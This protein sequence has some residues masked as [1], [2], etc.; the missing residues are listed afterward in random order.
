MCERDGAAGR[1]ACS[2]LQPLLSA[3]S[4]YSFLSLFPLSMSLYPLYKEKQSPG[5][6]VYRIL[7]K[8]GGEEGRG[9]KR[10]YWGARGG[11]MIVAA[12]ERGSER[13]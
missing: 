1:D 11:G 2:L 12:E 4:I 10:L 3:V 13:K 9:R 8:F 5:K 6:D 7:L